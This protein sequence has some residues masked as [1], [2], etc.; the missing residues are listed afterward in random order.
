MKMRAR[1]VA[2]LLGAGAAA[3]IV[4]V[5]ATGGRHRQLRFDL[6]TN[7]GRGIVAG[8]STSY[9]AGGASPGAIPAIIH[10]PNTLP[11]A[12]PALT[13]FLPGPN[14]SSY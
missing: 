4:L 11:A 14:G 7:H 5:L 13:H 3:A 1:L 9:L 2:A 12:P 6:S 8:F 10:P